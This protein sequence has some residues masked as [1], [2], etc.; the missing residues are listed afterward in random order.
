MEPF[1]AF[2][3][4][5]LPSSQLRLGFLMQSLLIG[6]GAVLSTALPWI[7]THLGYGGGPTAPGAIPHS[8]HIAFYMGSVVFLGSVV[9]TVA[10]TP[11]IPPDA[12]AAPADSGRSALSEILLGV[13]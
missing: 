8:V 5:L 3:G 13:R 9:Y 10:T 12:S 1:R 11:E 6:L 2:V 7:L 4:D